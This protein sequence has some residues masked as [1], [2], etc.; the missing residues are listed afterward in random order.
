MVVLTTGGGLAVLISLW[1]VEARRLSR[2]RAALPLRIAVTGTRGKSTVTRLLVS[3]LQ[4]SGYRVVGKTTGSRPVLILPDGSEEMIFRRGRPTPLEQR[5][6]L[7][8][9]VDLG[10][11]ALVAEM[12]SVRPESL[13]VESRH[14]L[15]PSL[16]VITNVLS[17]HWEHWGPTR[18]GAAAC[19]AAAVPESGTVLMPEKDALPVFLGKAA[20]RGARLIP[21]SVTPY[22]G[23]GGTDSDEGAG[24][25]ENLAL[26]R[27][28]ADE[29]ALKAAAVERGL[30]RARR[31]FGALRAW[32]LPSDA[33]GS[34]LI[35]VSAF[36]ANDPVSSRRAMDRVES[37][38][39]MKTREKIGLLNLRSDRMDRTRQWL[40]ALETGGFSGLDGLAVIG[41]HAAF[42]SR[43]L[44]KRG[45]ALRVLRLRGRS[46]EAWMRSLREIAPDDAVVLGLGNIAG[47]GAALIGEWERKG[48]PYAL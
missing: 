48:E 8:R 14:L 42:F 39:D 41:E 12:M 47:A 32:R 2:L 43:R 30:R 36:A 25:A 31:D 29:L 40:T 28:L 21:V 16:L 7:R 45:S 46:P 34:A 24:F 35:C 4:E 11:D 13:F 23:A 3:V 1:A 5:R 15:R 26:V 37:S 19:L 22:A 33:S 18:E 27:A 20:Q 10:A 17:D 6:V 38:R 9:A 44:L